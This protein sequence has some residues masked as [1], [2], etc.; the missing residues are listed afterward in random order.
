M[1]ILPYKDPILRAQLDPKPNDPILETD[2]ADI[3]PPDL[4]AALAKKEQIK[5]EVKAK[6][7]RSKEKGSSEIER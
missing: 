4:R 6:L 7:A 5:N 2:R 1:D 3:L